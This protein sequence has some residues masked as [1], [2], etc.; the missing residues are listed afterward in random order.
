MTEQELKNRTQKF[1][2]SIF[3]LIDKLPNT[4]SANI[5]GNQLGRAGSAVAANYRS[6][7]KPKSRA[8]FISKIGIVEQEAD[9][10][11]YWLNMLKETGNG[12]TEEINPLIKEADELTAIFTASGK[13]AKRNRD[14]ATSRKL[15]SQAPSEHK[16]PDH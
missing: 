14:G 3:K 12:S 9:E 10:S 6:A 8:D 16:L 7:C 4:K 11:E 13:T 15:K 5:I 2:V 1:A